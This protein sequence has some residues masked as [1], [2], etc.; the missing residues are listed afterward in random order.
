MFY[1]LPLL[2]TAMPKQTNVAITLTMLT[3]EI[4]FISRE[5]KKNL[6]KQSVLSFTVHT[7]TFR[8]R[9]ITLN[10]LFYSLSTIFFRYIG[11]LNRKTNL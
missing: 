9:L 6:I 3:I 7:L 1:Y 4:N 11:N 8:F 2:L 10:C 5:N